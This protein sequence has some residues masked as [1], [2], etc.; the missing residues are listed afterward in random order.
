MKGDAEYEKIDAEEVRAY[1]SG[2]EDVVKSRIFD[3]VFEDLAAAKLLSLRPR[4]YTRSDS[5]IYGKHEKADLDVVQL[6]AAIKT[7]MERMVSELPDRA[8]GTADEPGSS[9]PET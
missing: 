4:R 9:T 5:G 8:S 6:L 1:A 2:L 7:E 3:R